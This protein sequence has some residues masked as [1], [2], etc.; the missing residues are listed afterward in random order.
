MTSRTAVRARALAPVLLLLVLTGCRGQ[1][2]QVG[3][4]APEAQPQNTSYELAI[5][6]AFSYEPATLTVPAGTV[7]E[8]INRATT[9]HSVTAD[10]ASPLPFD[11]RL[12]AQGDTAQLRLDEPGRYPYH[13]SRHPDLMNGLIVV[14]PSS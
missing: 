10:V 8:V 5:D 3:T 11:T 14:E 4:P 1:A 6:D 2:A 7:I 13:C 9:A 12:I